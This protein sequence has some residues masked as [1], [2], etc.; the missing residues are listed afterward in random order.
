MTRA[1]PPLAAMPRR[2]PGAG[3]Q[4]LDSPAPTPH[5]IL[6]GK[7]AAGDTPGRQAL[8]TATALAAALTCS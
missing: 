6:S 2:H 8:T 5:A 7:D 4:L 1:W 3:R